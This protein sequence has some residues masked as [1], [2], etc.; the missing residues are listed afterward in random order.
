MG[1]KNRGV[2][3]AAAAF[4]ASPQ[5]RRM[6]QKAKDYAQR[7]ENRE[8]AQKLLAQAQEYAQRPENRARAQKLLAQ[9][10]DLTR[11]KGG[12]APRR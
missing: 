2:L 8:R 10:Q 3:A 12:P 6:V 1:K 9:A 11:R 4:A 5:G 7:P